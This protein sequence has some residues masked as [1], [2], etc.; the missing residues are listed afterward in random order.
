MRQIWS[1]SMNQEE[2]H[3]QF[4]SAMFVR[5][6]RKGTREREGGDGCALICRNHEE[7]WQTT[8]TQFPDASLS[9]LAHPA[10]ARTIA[11]IMSPLRCSDLRRAFS[12]TSFYLFIFFFTRQKTFGRK[13][14]ISRMQAAFFRF[15]PVIVSCNF[16]GEVSDENWNLSWVP[17]TGS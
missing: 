4:E 12:P 13:I 5:E 15:I 8:M 11:S 17:N 6:W 2:T 10:K 9:E 1:D 3:G 14:E 7:R 16:I